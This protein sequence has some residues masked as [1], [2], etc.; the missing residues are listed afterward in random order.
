[1]E[2]RE[3]I[4]KNYPVV[5]DFARAMNIIPQNVYQYLRGKSRFVTVR[6]GCVVV[7]VESKVITDADFNNFVIDEI[8]AN[9][10][11]LKPN[12][13]KATVELLKSEIKGRKNG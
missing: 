2:L 11:A 1:M 3:F 7:A 13:L 12:E 9:L 8:K 4:T 10:S 6:N 5:A